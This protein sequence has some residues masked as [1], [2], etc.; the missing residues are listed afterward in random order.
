MGVHIK[1]VKSPK[2]IGQ[3]WCDAL[4][5]CARDPGSNSYDLNMRDGAQFTQNTIELTIRKEQGVTDGK[6]NIPDL[7]VASINNGFSYVIV[8][9]DLNF[10]LINSNLLIIGR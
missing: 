8:I 5:K 10:T 6:K 3:L 7:P 2:P 1:G 4:G 9:T